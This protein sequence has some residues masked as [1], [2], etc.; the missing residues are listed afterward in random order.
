MT[1][2]SEEHEVIKEI[3][4]DWDDASIEKIR[5]KNRTLKCPEFLEMNSDLVIQ[6]NSLK[7]TLVK[8]KTGL[9]T[10]VAKDFSAQVKKNEIVTTIRFKI[11]KRH[12]LTD[13]EWKKECERLYEVVTKLKL[14]RCKIV[15]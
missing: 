9:E 7:E 5:E 2:A 11:D 14:K 15:E 10:L 4:L 13:D 8:E 12:K 1:G 6:S 3:S